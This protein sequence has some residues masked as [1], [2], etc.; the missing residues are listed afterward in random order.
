[1]ARKEE[2]SH[3]WTKSERVGEVTLFLT[4]RSPYWQMYWEIEVPAP[5]GQA[6]RAASPRQAV[7]KSTRETDLAF[8]RLVAGRRSEELFRGRH[9]PEERQAPQQTRIGPVFDAFIAYIETLDR[10]H[11]YV[12]KL[13]GRLKCLIGWMEKRRLV[14]VQDISASLL[15]RFQTYLRTERGVTTSTANHYLDAVHN[16]CGYA[17]FKRKL[18]AGPNPAAT[19]RQAELDRLPRRT[20]PPP[21][22]YPDQVNAVIEAAANHFDTQI[23]NLIVFICEG[24]FR[25]QEL[26]FLQ[27]GDIDLKEREIILDIKRPEPGRVRPELRRR[28]LTA[29]GLWVPK[30]R[31]ARRPVHIT[32]RLARTIGSMG[33]GQATDWVFLNQAGNQIA[34]NKTLDHL[35]RYALEA[36]VLVEP[37]PKTGEP[38]SLLR[39]HW[40]RHYHRTRAHV[41][42]I[43]REVSKLAMGHAADP[44]HDHYR[45]LDRFAFHAEYAKFESGLDDALLTTK[46]A[47]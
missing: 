7:S 16:F 47:P 46:K 42:K 14:F 10:S 43:R 3:R 5:N 9:Y 23:V 34:G 25:F 28:C 6:G 13:K 26:Q 45:G 30:S 27:V 17:I 32:D 40:L 12:S 37:H 41:S 33:L 22:I 15:Q 24:G 8:A 35:K 11:D 29:E 38:W 31:A 18:M 36:D 19:G 2:R 44:V 21:T 1:M 4:P 39:W 20:L